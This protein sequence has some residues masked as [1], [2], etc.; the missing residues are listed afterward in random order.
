MAAVITPLHYSL[1]LA[2]NAQ[3]EFVKGLSRDYPFQ[4][5][6]NEPEDQFVARTYLQF[7]WLPEVCLIFELVL[8]TGARCSNATMVVNHASSSGRTIAIPNHWRPVFLVSS[9]AFPT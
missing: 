7:L 4:D 6:H 2:N 3:K 9:A 8:L 1:V 5:L